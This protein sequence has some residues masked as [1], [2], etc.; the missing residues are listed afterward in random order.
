VNCLEFRRLTGAEPGLGTAEVEAHRAACPACA[1]F[2]DRMRALD[3]DIGRALAVD[4]TAL[5][6]PVRRGAGGTNRQPMPRWYALAAS[7]VLGVALAAALWVS[8]P[9]PTVAAEVL[10]HLRHEPEAWS[11]GEVL[12]PEEVAAVLGTA[13]VRL[14]A[15]AADVTYARRCWHQRHWVP[16]LVVRTDVGPVTVLLLAHREVQGPVPVADE[17][18]TGVVLP[19]PRGSIAIAARADVDID[20]VARQVFAAVDWDA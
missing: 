19:A 5:S 3:A 2:Q 4:A 18:F 20:A 14:R 11:A 15:G 6:K 7:L 17:E 13:G 10:D 12:S 8:F 1:R 16:H 9:A